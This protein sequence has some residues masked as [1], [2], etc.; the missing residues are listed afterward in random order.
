VSYLKPLYAE[1]EHLPACV[2]RLR[3]DKP[4]FHV[5]RTW[6]AQMETTGS[7]AD[8]RSPSFT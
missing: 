4:V 6:K 5:K 7:M 8:G 2:Y 1:Q 3:R